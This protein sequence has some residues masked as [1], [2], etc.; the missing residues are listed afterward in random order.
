VTGLF[1][2]KTKAW[3]ASLMR[4][5]DLDPSKFP[6]LVQSSERVGG[7]KPEAA[8]ALGLL[9][10]TP[11]FVHAGPFANIAH[12]NNSIVADQIALKLV[13]KDYCQAVPTPS[14]R[15]ARWWRSGSSTR[16]SKRGGNTTGYTS[17]CPWISTR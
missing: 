1:N 14:P 11:V 6:D 12:G 5:F 9:E 17:S 2:L 13:G 7:L 4:L 3:D 10:G 15:K 8:A 16:Y